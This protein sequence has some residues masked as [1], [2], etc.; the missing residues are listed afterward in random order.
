MLKQLKIFAFILALANSQC[1]MAQYILQVTDQKGKALEDISVYLKKAT[2]MGKPQLFIT[3]KKG[4]VELNEGGEFAIIIQHP[5]Y[6]SFSRNILI[7]KGINNLQI[8]ELDIDLTE[9]V[10]TGQYEAVSKDRALQKV[11]VI[12]QKRIENQGALTLAEVLGYEMNIRLNR[13]NILGTGAG[14]QG[15]GGQMLKIM[16]DGVPVI[17]RNDGNIDISQI[18]LAN[19]ERIEIIEGPMSVLYGT[20][21][22]GGVI[23][24]ITKKESDNKLKGEVY[25][26]A[27]S[28]GIYNF[29]GSASGGGKW[30]TLSANLGRNFSEGMVNPNVN[31]GDIWKPREQFFADVNYGFKVKNVS[32]RL[33]LNGFRE[34]LWDRGEAISTPIS[35]YAFD[36]FF[37]TNRYSAGLFTD[38][39]IGKGFDVQLINSFSSFS[40]IKNTYR[41]D[42]TTVEDTW[43][44]ADDAN[45]TSTFNLVLNR[46]VITSKWKKAVNVQFG[47]DFNTEW[48][49]G[50]RILGENQSIG[51][52]A[53]FGSVMYKSTR[54][55]ANAGARAAYNTRYNA[56][57]VANLNIRYNI[58][59]LWSVKAAYAQ[60]FRAPSLKELNLFFVDQNHNIQGNPNLAAETSDNL[61]GWITYN[62]RFQNLKFKAE[63]GG[64]YN[65]VQNMI[66][67][68][69]IDLNTQ[70]YSYINI[71][72]FKTTG[73]VFMLEVSGDRFRA[74]VS[75][76]FTWRS[77]NFEGSGFGQFLWT[78]EI[79]SQVSF[80]PIKRAATELSVF[81]KYNG[82]MPG[83]ALDANGEPV[84]TGIDA[85]SLMDASVNQPLFNRK[86]M[87]ILGVR[88]LFDVT[89]INMNGPAGGAHSGP[90]TGMNIG[91]GRSVFS[92]LRIR[93]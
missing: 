87:W 2:A 47:Y 56:P 54:I 17:G 49:Q 70:L 12:D 36:R 76:G 58:S 48:A 21:A 59:S 51:D 27:E 83:V 31:R 11:R 63:L 7:S 90:A 93:F 35:I 40:R 33:Q 1:L 92:S 61:S 66:T 75:E 85:Y 20:D 65:H 71:N 79:N 52:Y 68:A 69:A 84:Q 13:D 78:P 8:K 46:A 72:A 37:Y 23:N 80:K 64:F 9:V 25:G 44:P 45:D 43:V 50:Q 28:T 57:I 39:K 5:A 89:N 4:Q 73:G 86:V 22:I 60:G 16:V 77:Y 14:L 62:S 74:S 3:D 82:Y 67:L 38:F 55:Q 29:G 34:T 18:N 19:I 42:L 53:A 88:N 41:R 30:G 24:L 6:E 81:Y 26:F 15:M 10:V 32:N 91:M